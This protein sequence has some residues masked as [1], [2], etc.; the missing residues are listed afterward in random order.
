MKH[1]GTDCILQTHADTHLELFTSEERKAALTHLLAPVTTLA[2]V[3]DNLV[4]VSVCVK[5][6]IN[7]HCDF[8]LILAN[9][10]WETGE[11]CIRKRGVS[12][13]W[14]VK[15]CPHVFKLVTTLRVENLTRINSQ[16]IKT[17]WIGPSGANKTSSGLLAQRSHMGKVK[18]KLAVAINWVYD[19]VTYQECSVGLGSG[20]FGG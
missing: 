3:A 17:T 16:K 12:S 14:L 19:Y 7:M 9:I 10:H 11:Q 20:V 4:L 6:R 2:R 15:Y 13:Q 18:R 8:L 1:C 5:T